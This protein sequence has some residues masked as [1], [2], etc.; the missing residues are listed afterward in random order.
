LATVVEAYGCAQGYEWQPVSSDPEYLKIRRPHL[1]FLQL[2][3]SF[4]VDHGEKV[5]D[6]GRVKAAIDSGVE[7][8]LTKKTSYVIEILSDP[9]VTPDGPQPEPSPARTFVPRA[10]QVGEM[11]PPLEQPPIDVYY[12]AEIKR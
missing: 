12:H 8:V 7:H 11:S 6:P 9:A 1:D 4:G 10:A 5:T 3:R 2:A